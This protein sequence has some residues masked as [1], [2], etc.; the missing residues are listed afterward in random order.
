LQ[1]RKSGNQNSEL[2]LS[3]CLSVNCKRLSYLRRVKSV[4]SFLSLSVLW[5]LSS[6]YGS[7]LSVWLLG[8][9]CHFLIAWW[10]LSLFYCLV[11]SVTFWLLGD[12]CHSLV[13]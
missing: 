1:K 4:S 8:D 10:P 3:V 2:R 7:D 5:F 12:L 9:L 11:T 6:R 13:A